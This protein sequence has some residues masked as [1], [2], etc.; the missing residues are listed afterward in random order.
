M[1]SR[2]DT[3]GFWAHSSADLL[4]TLNTSI[5]GLAGDDAARRLVQYGSNRLIAKKRTSPLGLLLGQFKSPITLLLLFAAIL[6]FFLRDR[7]DAIIILVII[8]VSGLLGFWQEHGAKS[9]VEKLLAL[10]AVKARVRRAGQAIELPIDEIVPGDIVE[11]SAGASIPGDCLLLE[12][13]D[14]FVN[15]ATLTG[16]TYPVEKAPGLLPADAPLAKRSN[17]LF[18]GTHVVS[19]TAVA[20]VVHTGRQ[21]ELGRI[22]EHLRLRPPETEFERGVR[23]FGYLLL[24]VTLVLLI[25]IFA[26]NVYLSKP[27]MDSFLFALALAVGLT[28][29]LLPAIISVNLSHGARGMAEHKVIVKRLASIENFGSMTVLCSDKTGTLTEGAIRIESAVDIHG[30]P[31][32]QVLRAA[33][34][35][36]SFESGYF[37]PIDEAIRTHRSFDISGCEKLYELPYD[38]LR[39]R[40]S[41]LVAEGERHFIVTKGAF[42][43][44]ISV[45]SQAETTEG[46]VIGIEEVREKVEQRFADWSRQAFRV[47]V[48]ARK[49]V[50]AAT[51]ITRADEADMTLV[52]FLLLHDPLKSDIVETVRSLN[53]LGVRLKGITGDN[54]LV[55]A[56]VGKQIGWPEPV[57]LSGPDL[58]QMSD[59]A[60]LRRVRDVDL[61]AE[62]E[63][64]QKERIILALRKAGCVVGYMGDG[65]NDAPAL[66]AADVSISVN[67]AVDVAKDAADIVLLERGLD[68]LVAG[69]REGRRTFANTLKYVHMATSANFGNMFSMAGASLFLPFLPL[70]PKQ[71]LLTNLMTDFPEMA[72]ATDSVD[73]DLVQ[74][75]RRWDIR[76]IRRFMLVFGVLSSVFDYLTFGV[77]MLIL[78]ATPEQFRTGWFVESVISAAL[79][80]LV[81]RSR[82]PF[83]RSRP[84]WMLQAATFAMVA[85]TLI[86]PYSPLAGVLGFAPL[87]ARFVVI[88]LAIVA[89]YLLSAEMVKRVFHQRWAT[90]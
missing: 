7:T 27:V 19:G 55:A 24:E 28:P 18:M 59:E 31:S 72:I 33:F 60:L 89:A 4:A 34:L 32:D 43:N 73:A 77:L 13:Q 78:H 16:E 58:R 30:Q 84:G 45:C 44:V 15:E 67:T 22:S 80:V 86:I 63:P 3:S 88:M 38:F 35:N 53:A 29:Q 14:L 57:V 47:L 68:V 10:V 5:A 6:S 9:A 56:A 37:N 85:V 25:A 21:T 50:G 51:T 41:I 81:I 40:L 79:V 76:F 87:P 83:F 61:F 90:S 11:L 69:V 42:A 12:A 23:R 20:V 49:D 70:L 46:R 71:I 82:R 54:R 2:S 65:I 1:N 64:N 8:A 17:A 66:H 26:I 75:P 62:V 36:A 74:Q 52:G 39:K 48:V